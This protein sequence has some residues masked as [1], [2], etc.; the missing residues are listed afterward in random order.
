MFIL[1]KNFLLGPQYV[2]NM[3]SQRELKLRS[4]SYDWEKRDFTFQK[5]VNLH[6][7]QHIIADGLMGYGYSGVDDTSKVI[8]IMSGINTNALNACKASILAIPEI[9]GEFDITTRNF[10]DFISMSRSLQNNA[11]AKVSSVTRIRGGSRSDRGS[12]MNPESDAQATMDAIKNKYFR[13]SE[14]GYVPTTNYKKMS[15]TQKQAVYRLRE[16]QYG[17]S[18]PAAG[19]VTY[20]EYTNLKR[21]VSAFSK[22]VDDSLTIEEP[23]GNE[24][25]DK[26]KKAKSRGKKSNLALGRQ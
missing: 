4:F 21:Q 20:K 18:S 16:E 10:I 24:D 22:K 2:T 15:K 12:G 23:S 11:T 14:Q 3:A 8:I 25:G 26:K 9:K 7:G 13:G 6:K 17:S 19:A 5:F 1:L